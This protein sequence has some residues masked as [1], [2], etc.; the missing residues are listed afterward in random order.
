MPFDRVP[1]VLMHPPADLGIS[2]VRNTWIGIEVQRWI[3]SLRLNRGDT[4]TAFLYVFPESRN[5]R[6]VGQNGSCSHNR[7]RTIRSIFHDETPAGVDGSTLR[8]Q[9][10]ALGRAAVQCSC[11]VIHVGNKARLRAVNGRQSQTRFKPG[12]LSVAYAPGS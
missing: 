8:G 4:V 3:P 5:V 7:Y 6:G 12:H 9:F 11:Y 10:P 1:N 2:L